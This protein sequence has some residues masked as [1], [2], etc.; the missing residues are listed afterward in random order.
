MDP[1][2][3]TYLPVETDAEIV[4]LRNTTQIDLLQFA[5]RLQKDFPKRSQGADAALGAIKR[6]TPKTLYVWGGMSRVGGN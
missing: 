5:L 6:T 2:Y 4:K 1:Q 3:S